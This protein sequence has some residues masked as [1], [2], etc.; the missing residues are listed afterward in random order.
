MNSRHHSRIIATTALCVLTASAVLADDNNSAGE[1]IFK[2]LDRNRDGA[3]DSKEFAKTPLSMRTWLTTNRLKPAPALKKAAFLKIYGQMMA[4][5]RKA[6]P[7]ASTGSDASTGSGSTGTGTGTGGSGSLYV[8]G[9]EPVEVVRGGSPTDRLPAEYQPGDA[10]KDGQIDFAEWRKWKGGE[11]AKFKELDKNS[12]SLLSP[13]E[14]GATGT[15]VASTGSSSSSGSS[16]TSSSNNTPKQ[17]V[18]IEPYD[19]LS[20]DLKKKFGEVIKKNYFDYL[21]VD[22]SGKLEPREWA[23][24][25]RISAA[26]KGAKIDLDKDM[27]P[28]QFI[29]HYSTVVGTQKTGVW[30]EYLEKNPPK[31]ATKSDGDAKKSDGSSTA[32]K[33]DSKSSSSK[34]GGDTYDTLSDD[35]K[36]EYRAIVKGYFDYL[37]GKPTKDY[38]GAKDGNKDGKL[39]PKEWA[40]SSRIKKVFADAKIDLTKEMTEAEFI[41]HYTRL[42]GL[43]DRTWRRNNRERRR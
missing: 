5:L 24:S 37:D 33:D 42:V 35:K 29:T 3:I 30:K 36:K 39:Q 28:E 19:K 27:T 22:K 31:S 9:Q 6:K 32:K 21:D 15:T 23:A 43:K 8:S 26:F 41:G 40:G 14:L 4:D 13:K 34:S 1:R 11:L 16:G 17:P 18:V 12:D 25:R 10:N 20:D 2:Y 7:A 38:E